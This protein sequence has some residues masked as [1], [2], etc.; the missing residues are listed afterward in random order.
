MVTFSKIFHYN[1]KHFRADPFSLA[2]TNG[3][4]IVIFSSR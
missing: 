2:T 1:Y 4:T 3:I